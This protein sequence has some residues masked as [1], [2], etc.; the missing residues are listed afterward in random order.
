LGSIWAKLQAPFVDAHS[1]HP[2]LDHVRQ[3]ANFFLTFSYLAC[4]R[5][6]VGDAGKG[7]KS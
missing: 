5:M 1:A 2:E 6:E 3:L 4:M 7:K